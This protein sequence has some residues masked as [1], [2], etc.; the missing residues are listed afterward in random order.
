MK[1]HL[2]EE[3]PEFESVAGFNGYTVKYRNEKREI[4]I[5]KV[6]V[7]GFQEYIFVTFVIIFKQDFQCKKTLERSS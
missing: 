6:A 5:E 7:L 1:I 3:H 2:E 4:S